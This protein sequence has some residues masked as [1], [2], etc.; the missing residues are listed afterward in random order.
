M[1]ADVSL[2]ADHSVVILLKHLRNI[3]DHDTE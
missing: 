1:E 2:S 3:F